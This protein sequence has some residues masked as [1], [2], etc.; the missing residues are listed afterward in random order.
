MNLT[1]QRHEDTEKLLEISRELA[2]FPS[3]QAD[4]AATRTLRYV[5]DRLTD[6]T[7]RVAV[8]GEFS[9]G[10]STFINALVGRDLLSHAVRETTAAITYIQN[11][12]AGDR[13]C[14]TCEVVYRDGHREALG[15]L[16]ELRHYTTVQSG[17][18][19]AEKISSVTVYVHFLPTDYPVVITDT[20][21]LNGIADRHREITVD[22]VKKAHA[23]VYLLSKNGVK[24]TDTEFIKI[25]LEY[26]NTIFFLQ[27]FIDELRADEGDTV[28]RKLE[29]AEENIVKHVVS[30]SREFDRRIMGISA[31]KALAGKD[32]TIPRLYQ[33][34]EVDLTPAQRNRLLAESGLPDF[35]NALSELI[36]SGEYRVVIVTAAR[37]V[38]KNLMEHLLESLLQKQSLNEQLRADSVEQRRIQAAEGLLETIEKGKSDRERRLTNYID[39]RSEEQQR[40]LRG[41]IEKQLEDICNAISTEIDDDYAAVSSQP[42]SESDDTYDD[43]IQKNRGKGAAEYYSDQTSVRVNALLREINRSIGGYLNLIYEEALSRVETFTRIKP[44][45]KKIDFS[46]DAVDNAF[47]MDAFQERDHKTVL[48]ELESRIASHREKIQKLTEISRILPGQVNQKKAELAR[49]KREKQNQISNRDKA[50]ADLGSRPEV[51]RWTEP[52]NREVPRGGIVGL[53]IKTRTEYY[54]V[55]KE[56]DSDQRAWDKKH[57]EIT[58]EYAKRIEDLENDIF[59]GEQQVRELAGEYE[60]TERRIR[61]LKLDVTDCLEDVRM[62]NEKYKL[63]MSTARRQFFEYQKNGLKN[64]LKLRLLESEKDDSVKDRLNAHIR[65]I[66]KKHI[67]KI[68]G[69][70][71]DTYRKSVEQ[72][73]SEIRAM[74]NQSKAELE[75]T[76]H[77]SEQDIQGLQKLLASLPA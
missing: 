75:Q 28:E 51:R 30:G 10:K 67:G 73:E 8:V 50:L 55:Q 11:V 14:E 33:N 62:E 21:G 43:V 15:R 48:N 6:D 36:N 53:F 65:E 56:D 29:E 3:V 25:L 70:L 59:D 54:P 39:S 46:I 41:Y 20:P 23:C 4:E 42:F 37:D 16:D 31:L 63:L 27:N 19:V 35:E 74:L 72:Q 68:K 12:P 38:L 77:S 9:S 44:N 40:A 58:A 66:Y 57:R 52:H 45:K 26:Q 71:L 24:L 60:E 22:E 17:K 18:Q 2:K 61:Q 69:T 49:N 47:Q 64:S 7:F 76:Y 13:R 1:D 32:D 34:D 5:E